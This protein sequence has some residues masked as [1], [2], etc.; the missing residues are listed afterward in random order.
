MR[1]HP[2]CCRQEIMMNSTSCI[3]TKLSEALSTHAVCLSQKEVMT[4]MWLTVSGSHRLSDTR[5]TF[6]ASLMC[7]CE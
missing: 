2:V 5:N 7:S 4:S 3:V 6:A 1:V